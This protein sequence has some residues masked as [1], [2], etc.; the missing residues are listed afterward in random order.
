MILTS[1]DTNNKRKV[2]FESLYDGLEGY[3]HMAA[4]PPGTRNIHN[5]FFI[6][7]EQKDLVAD[8]QRVLLC[9]CLLGHQGP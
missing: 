5:E 7:P 8:A 4:L 2:F 1:E 9:D 3:V 6:W